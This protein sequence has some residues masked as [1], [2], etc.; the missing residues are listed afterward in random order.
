MYS[1]D[2][3]EEE[4][5]YSGSLSASLHE[6]GHKSENTPIISPGAR[7]R[8]RM[9]V[10]RETEHMLKRR[11]DRWNKLEYMVTPHMTYRTGS[12]PK[13]IPKWDATKSL[14]NLPQFVRN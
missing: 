12:P 4:G 11:E 5:V 10:K 14:P 6:H 9:M 1:A 8:S 2:T 3:E 7:E 13:G